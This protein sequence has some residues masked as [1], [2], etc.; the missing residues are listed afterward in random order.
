MALTGVT[1][2]LPFV[3]IQSLDITPIAGN[4]ESGT[5]DFA[6]IVANGAITH[7][8]VR[9]SPAVYKNSV[10]LNGSQGVK[11]DITWDISHD[12]LCYCYIYAKK[13]TS[14]WRFLRVNGS[15]YGIQYPT[16]SVELSSYPAIITIYCMDIINA[17]SGG[18]F[19]YGLD[20]KNGAGVI[21]LDGNIGTITMKQLLDDM[22]SE[23]YANTTYA[24]YNYYN[25]FFACW[26]L[27]DK[28]TA[29]GILNVSGF[30]LWLYGIRISGYINVVSYKDRYTTHLMV[31]KSSSISSQ[32]YLKGANLVGC[33][34]SD[35]WKNVPALYYSGNCQF[36]F[37]AN[38]KLYGCVLFGGYIRSDL[39][40]TLNNCIGYGNYFMD[41]GNSLTYRLP[42]TLYGYLQIYSHNNNKFYKEWKII[43]PQTSNYH[44][45]YRM[46][47][48]NPN[49]YIQK[50]LDCQFIDYENN[51]DLTEV[52][53]TDY[54]TRIY[55]YGISYNYFQDCYIEHT[56]EITVH[57]SDGEY[58]NAASILIKDKDDN[59][60]DSGNSDE[61]GFLSKI[62]K[63]R[64][65]QYITNAADGYFADNRNW[66]LTNYFP[67][68]IEISK[69]GFVDKSVILSMIDGKIDIVADMTYLKPQI[70]AVSI[71][72]C[73]V[74]GASNG[75]IEITADSYYNVEY[76]INGTD[77]Q[78]S[79]IFADLAKGTY[80]VYVKDSNGEIVSMEDIEVSEPVY[81]FVPVHGINGT[82]QLHRI[83]GSVI[84]HEIT[85]VVTK[86]EITGNIVK[87]EIEG[88]VTK[89]EIT[90]EV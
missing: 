44:V 34:L 5:W 89:H 16:I 58:I 82:V 27:R 67:I 80:T 84:K 35:G 4:W 21:E 23:G 14:I 86:H 66:T 59:I 30:E 55:W 45:Y 28:S 17:N 53:N 25:S 61:N 57:D 56:F 73:T 79:N 39:P 12:S 41:L 42:F 26:S 33:T 83:N 70:T 10:I 85:G 64:R 52:A 60:L 76:S 38:S 19:P 81:E 22:E 7:S 54:P 15:Y 11:I 20:N 40:E 43:I 48:A 62:I 51:S 1:Y 72:D 37:D 36:Y 31:Y 77:Y 71:T 6:V 9:E 74:I 32:M 47:S 90:G 29:S 69:E 88:E 68:T 50:F 78:E 46:L 49:S 3:G 63:T 8:S 75:Q 2:L 24:Q 87:H 13:S 65:I 18:Q